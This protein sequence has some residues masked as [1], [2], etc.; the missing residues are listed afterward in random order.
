[1]GV[2]SNEFPSTFYSSFEGANEAVL[3][4]PNDCESGAVFVNF[5]FRY[6]NDSSALG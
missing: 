1:M 3:T 6:I 5:A 2:E 4:F